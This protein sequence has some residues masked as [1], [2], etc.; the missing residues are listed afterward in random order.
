[1]SSLGTCLIR[2]Y[3]IR[4]NDDGVVEFGVGNKILPI[5]A[6]CRIKAFYNEGSD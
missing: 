2:V 3:D 5:L 4:E 1:M 6:Y